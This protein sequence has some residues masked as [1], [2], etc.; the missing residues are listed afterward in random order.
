[1]TQTAA[2]RAWTSEPAGR[3]QNRVE[4]VSDY[5]GFLALEPAWNALMEA[6]GIDHPFLEHAW[7]R[8]WW[9]CFGADSRLHILVLKEAD[10]IV[11]IA[12]LISTV[13]RMFGIPVRRLGFFYNAHVPRADFLIARG[14]EH[15]YRLIWE[16]LLSISSSWD[17]LQLCQLPRKPEA[18]TLDAILQL[19]SKDGFPTGVWCSGA[20][21]Y[22][23][24]DTCWR[25]YHDSLAAKHRSNLR[26]RFKRLNQTGL[27]T[28][29]TITEQES[30]PE[31]LDAGFR[32][33]ESS[34][35]REAGT[36]I[37]CALWCCTPCAEAPNAICF[38]PSVLLRG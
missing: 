17:L 14:F 25:Q 11:A 27:V 23:A 3:R 30:L 19:A 1:M 29:E 7:V 18:G 35:K 32:L 37:S 28:L 4:T 12:P 24:L 22:V 2:T 15:A 34:W 26:N 9:E 33:E 20:S 8:T 36:A 38:G 6:S 21:P 13:V 16:H 5:R 10:E 31:A